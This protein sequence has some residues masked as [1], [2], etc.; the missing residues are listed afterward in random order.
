MST[1]PALRKR[2]PSS[3]VVTADLSAPHGTT[4][5]RLKP[6]L[7]Q[8]PVSGAMSRIMS[9]VFG[10]SNNP[11]ANLSA[12]VAVPK[13]A[14]YNYHEGDL[15]TPGTGNYVFDYQFEYPLQTV[16]GSG[17]LRRAN[18]FRPEQP[19]Q[20]YQNPYITQIGVGGLVAGQFTHTP[21]DVPQDNS[22]EL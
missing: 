11:S 20:V 19:A 9:G 5:V 1:I 21:L 16:W 12:E 7:K 2:I 10:R 13:K 22:G 14:L 8:G 18:T 6:Q 4:G 3:P 15:F 17:F